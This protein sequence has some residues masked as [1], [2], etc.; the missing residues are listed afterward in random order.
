MSTRD[1][2]RSNYPAAGRS[3]AAARAAAIQPKRR[4]TPLEW[5]LI[6]GGVIAWAWCA[7]EVALLFLG[8]R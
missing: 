3:G 2:M 1:F 4:Y 6:G 7:Y 8:Q 5:A